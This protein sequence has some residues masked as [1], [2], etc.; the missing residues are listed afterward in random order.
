LGIHKNQ[1]VLRWRWRGLIGAL[2]CRHGA[3]FELEEDG[4]ACF[5]PPLQVTF[6]FGEDGTIVSLNTSLDAAVADINF[7]RRNNE[8]QPA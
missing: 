6:Q 5:F 2:L 4:H 3:T 7:R 8:V 1:G